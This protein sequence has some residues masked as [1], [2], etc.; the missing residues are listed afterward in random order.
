MSDFDLMT[1]AYDC[2]Y[3]NALIVRCENFGMCGLDVI[4]FVN[5]FR[6]DQCVTRGELNEQSR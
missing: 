2:G 4:I 1:A 3:L 6:D 5:V